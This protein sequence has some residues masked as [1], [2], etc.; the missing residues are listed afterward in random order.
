MEIP[1]SKNSIKE[2]LTLLEESAAKIKQMKAGNA[3]ITDF[4]ACR[5]L[6]KLMEGYKKILVENLSLKKQIHKQKLEMLPKEKQ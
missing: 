4:S 3:F 2:S 6:E 5:L 1:M